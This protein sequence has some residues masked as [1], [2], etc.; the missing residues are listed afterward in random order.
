M[1]SIMAACTAIL[2]AKVGPCPQKELKKAGLI[3]VEAY[4]AIET[5]AREFYDQNVLKA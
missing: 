1:R 5:V 4:D 3:V 2:A